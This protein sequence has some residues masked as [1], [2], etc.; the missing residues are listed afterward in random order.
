LDNK[1]KPILYSWL[2]LLLSPKGI[3]CF[4]PG[5]LGVFFV[6]W[7]EAQGYQALVL[8]KYHEHIAIGLMGVA[9]V[10]FLMRAV[11]YRMEIDFILFLIF[12]GIAAFFSINKQHKTPVNFSSSSATK[13]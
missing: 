3:W 11:R 12:S 7:A 8:K 2:R 9:T 6:Y 10:L 5:I 1:K 13:T 4:F